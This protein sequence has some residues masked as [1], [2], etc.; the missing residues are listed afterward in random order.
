M[1]EQGRVIVSNSKG[2]AR[3]KGVSKLTQSCLWRLQ[4]AFALT[5]SMIFPRSIRQPI[6]PGPG[7]LVYSMN[8]AWLNNLQP[9]R[10]ECPN[11][12]R[13]ITILCCV[14][15][16]RYTPARNAHLS[17]ALRFKSKIISTVQW[18]CRFWKQWIT[19][20]ISKFKIGG[21]SPGHEFEDTLYVDISNTR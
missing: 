20:W 8:I 6:T 21:H 3:G 12:H 5:Q 15:F 16:R 1:R 18:P 4:R 10:S 2:G 11:F 17:R 19:I 9:A 13:M 7:A 14:Y